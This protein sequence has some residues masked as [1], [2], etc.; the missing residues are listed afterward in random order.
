MNFELPVALEIDG[1]ERPIRSDYRVALDI[2]VALS[3]PEFTQSEKTIA[4]LSM[5]YIAPEEIKDFDAAVR[6]GLW[7]I[8]CGDDMTP[9]RK[10]PK[11]VDWEQDFP[12]IAAPI[13][14]LAGKEIR[15]M[16]YMHWWTFVSFYYEIGECTF[17]S[18]VSIRS[19][20]AK[21]KKLEKHEREFERENRHLINFKRRSVTDEER[22]FIDQLLKGGA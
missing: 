7:F 6:Q 4:L 17:A 12:Y 8:A 14:R 1:V 20:K 16:E 18:I 2:C 10:R 19:K 15:S 9:Q 13:N 22:D 3:D 11:L 21:G 5:L